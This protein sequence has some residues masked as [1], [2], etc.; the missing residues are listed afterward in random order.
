M[1]AVF[2][3]AGL[4]VGLVAVV[5]L[6]SLDER[7]EKA[8][9]RAESE[10]RP[11]LEAQ[12]NQQIE[13]YLAFVQATGAGDWQ[14][15]EHAIHTA[16]D[17]Y[18]ALKGARSYLGLRMADNVRAHF[19]AMYAV[20]NT[21]QII[22]GQVISRLP[23]RMSLTES[24]LTE[25]VKWLE[26]AKDHGEDPEGQVTAALAL[27]YGANGR[28]NKML[29]MLLHLDALPDARR[30]QL[31]QPD[32][33]LLLTNASGGDATLLAE[34]GKALGITLP[35]PAEE[36][37]AAIAGLDLSHTPGAL[38]YWAF[39]HPA[40]VWASHAP[41]FPA[42]IR[43]GVSNRADKRGVQL[44]WIAAGTVGDGSHRSIPEQPDQF[45]SPS[46]ALEETT[47]RFTI[48]AACSPNQ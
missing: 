17:R 13:G 23:G 32:S 5:T 11:K 29:E 48:I 1:G 36:V 33:L 21:I 8:Y 40:W 4:I 10:L 27:M 18:P 39:G 14:T 15:A 38:F 43:L 45:L 24:P 16:L 44:G 20:W 3:A 2:A 26:D 34:I 46:A 7:I 47:K 12:A 25:A 19:T 42:Q 35:V 6:L 22:D 31:R 28:A 30:N 9:Q 37:Q 41:R